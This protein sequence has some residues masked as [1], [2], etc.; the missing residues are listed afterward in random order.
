MIPKTDQAPA[1]TPVQKREVVQESAPKIKKAEPV[2]ADSEE[3][4]F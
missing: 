3:M 2:V 1:Q 4:D